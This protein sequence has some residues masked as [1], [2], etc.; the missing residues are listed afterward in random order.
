MI[1]PISTVPGF[2]ALPIWPPHS[3]VA[4]HL[5][6]SSSLLFS[7]TFLRCWPWSYYRLSGILLDPSNEIKF[8]ATLVGETLIL[9][10]V[11]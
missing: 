10:T 5:T 4:S 8:S 9:G 7:S 6:S 2:T 11:D 1:L 3:L